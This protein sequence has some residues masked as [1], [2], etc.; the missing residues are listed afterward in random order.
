MVYDGFDSNYFRFWANS[1][2]NLARVIQ[3]LI[4]FNSDPEKTG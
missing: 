2:P 3:I 1:M 4:N